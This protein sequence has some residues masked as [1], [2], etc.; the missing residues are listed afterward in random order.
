MRMIFWDDWKDLRLAFLLLF[1]VTELSNFFHK[2]FINSICETFPVENNEYTKLR[3][4]FPGC[5]F[6]NHRLSK[7]V[8]KSV[9][10]VNVFFLL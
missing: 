7:D 8:N 2:T 1:N 3:L 4:R 6:F 9:H 5:L 10:A